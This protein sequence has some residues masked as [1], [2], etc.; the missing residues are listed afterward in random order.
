MRGQASRQ[1]ARRHTYVLV[2]GGGGLGLAAIC[3]H[4]RD[5]AW[6]HPQP[7]R[8][9]VLLCQ[10]LPSRRPCAQGWQQASERVWRAPEERAGRQAAGWRWRQGLARQR[11]QAKQARLLRTGAHGGAHRIREEEGGELAE[12]LLAQHAGE[13][14]VGH[15]NARGAAVEDA[16]DPAHAAGHAGVHH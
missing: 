2:M 13:E 10:G 4:T 15:D 1:G 14:R 9:L 7:Y 11:A 5:C 8:P 12:G 3:T 6:G 16:G